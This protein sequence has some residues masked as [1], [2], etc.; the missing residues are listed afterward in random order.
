MEKYLKKAR[1][2]FVHENTSF[3][4]AKSENFLRGAFENNNLNGFFDSQKLFLVDHFLS[5]P[6]P[7]LPFPSFAFSFTIFHFLYSLAQCLWFRLEFS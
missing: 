5:L 6:F 3:S 4:D 7:S 1:V 2:I